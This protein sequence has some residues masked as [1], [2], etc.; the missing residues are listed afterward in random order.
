MSV[1]LKIILFITVIIGLSLGLTIFYL[2][3]KE[4]KPALKKEIVGRIVIN[5]DNYDREAGAFLSG[6][7]DRDKLTFA[8]MKF[9]GIH[10]ELMYLKVT[11]RNR[12]GLLFS[13][14]LLIAEDGGGGHVVLR[15]DVRPIVSAASFPADFTNVRSVMKKMYVARDFLP[16][17]E[18]RRGRLVS[19]RSNLNVFLLRQNHLLQSNRG[20]LRSGPAVRSKNMLQRNLFAAASARFRVLDG[21]LD[22]AGRALDQEAEFFEKEMDHLFRDLMTEKGLGKIRGLARENARLVERLKG[23]SGLIRIGKKQRALKKIEDLNRAGALLTSLISGIDKAA[24]ALSRLRK[25]FRSLKEVKL[26]LGPARFQN[27]PLYGRMDLVTLY[28]P[29]LWFNKRVGFYEIGISEDRI[30]SKVKPIII[31]GIR[32]SVVIVLISVVLGLFLAFYIIYPIHRLDREADHILRDIRYRI[33]VRRKDEFGKFQRTFNDLADKIT[34]ELIKYENL[35][36]EATRDE[37]TGLM[38][39]KYFMDMLRSELENAAAAGRSTSLL[40]TD[41][42]HFKKFNDTY[43]HQTGDAVL[44]EAASVL[45]KNI[46]KKGVLSDVAGRYGGEEFCMLLSGTKKE[47][48]LRIAERIRK[49]VEDLK[50]TLKDGTVLSVTISIGV[51]AAPDSA[52]EPEKLIARADKAL[53][54]SKKNG[55]N[56][57]S[58]A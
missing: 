15:K 3:N 16:E 28:R 47:D 18:K 36:N 19:L 48:A 50:V 2:S 6:L 34:T 51:A 39:R 9:F 41:I 58:C 29:I 42:D 20:I 54:Q 23:L 46:R 45:L 33:D 30:M 32:S 1:K 21:F 31:R 25:E 43:G 7:S 5:L 56:R 13:K 38:V 27:R 57:V 14:D 24:A 4:Y 8:L 49:K 37:L 12:K 10:E 40:M 52:L 44:A 22:R 17:L 35:Y 53:Y 11:G 55:R 26:D